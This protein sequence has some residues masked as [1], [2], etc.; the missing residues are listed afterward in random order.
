M[1]ALV[2][3][4]FLGNETRKDKDGNTVNYAVLLCGL[5]TV[6][7]KGIAL[8]DDRLKEVRYL[9]SFQHLRAVY[10]LNIVNNALMR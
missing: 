4:Q 5:E 8:N 3:G 2:K 10:T 1:N 9:F 7:I 6:K